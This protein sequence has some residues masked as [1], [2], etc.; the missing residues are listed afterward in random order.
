M[1]KLAEQIVEH[2]PTEDKV[3]SKTEEILKEQTKT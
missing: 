3:I 2:F 1:A